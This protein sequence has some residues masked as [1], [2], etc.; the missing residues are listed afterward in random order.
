MLKIKEVL[1]GSKERGK[2]IFVVPWAENRKVR[3]HASPSLGR[4]QNGGWA[5][6]NMNFERAT[7]GSTEDIGKRWRTYSVLQF[8]LK[9]LPRAVT[10]HWR[11][12]ALV[13]E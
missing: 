11:G 13:L 7:D 10:S 2:G 12:G 4:S 1:K 5:E 8:K 9:W 3:K 6:W